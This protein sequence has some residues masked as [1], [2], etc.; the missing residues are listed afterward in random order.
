MARRAYDYLRAKGQ[1]GGITADDWRK[2]EVERLTGFS[3]LTQCGADSYNQLA[4]H[5]ST[6]A[7]ED[8]EALR[9]ILRG[10]SNSV[11]QL[12]V[13][14]TRLLERA[15]L[16][17][18]YAEAVAIDRWK[19]PVEDLN[20]GELKQLLFTLSNRARSKA[21]KPSRATANTEHAPR[22]TH[23]DS[24]IHDPRFNMKSLLAVLAVLALAAT[25]PT[26]RA[27]EYAPIGT[28][29]SAPNFTNATGTA[30]NLAV[31]IDCTT[32]TD[33]SLTFEFGLTN[34]AAGSFNCRWEKSA[35]RNFL[36]TN[37]AN[38]ADSGWFAVPLT[39]RGTKTVWTTNITMDAIGYYR[40]V[41]GT[42]QIGQ[43]VTS[44]LVR[45]YAKPARFGAK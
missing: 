43:S 28:V 30:T 36:I 3:G 12:R 33:F 7:G 19:K 24:T 16:H 4:A 17:P 9:F 39:N 29:W 34:P 25:V 14:I 15:G 23:H 6:L 21:R 5:F 40:I 1:L 31:T 26:V 45:A 18:Q 44:A 42:N 35:T 10:E 20:E 2:H 22:T 8:G 38:H 11:R 41:W 27:A 37:I 32:T 13:V